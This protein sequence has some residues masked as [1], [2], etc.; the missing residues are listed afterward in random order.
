M[1]PIHV[2]RL[3]VSV[4]TNTSAPSTA[5]KPPNSRMS[6]CPPLMLSKNFATTAAVD[7]AS[8]ASV[9][10]AES[11]ASVAPSP[12]ACASAWPTSFWGIQRA[13]HW[14][15]RRPYSDEAPEVRLVPVGGKAR[16][17]LARDS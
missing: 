17:S 7:S 12:S 11:V 6:F 1:S 3:P 13:R 8:L 9:V 16:D 5:P 4:G 14:G 15:Q 10:L 2:S